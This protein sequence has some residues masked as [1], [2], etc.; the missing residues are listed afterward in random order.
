MVFQSAGEYAKIG[1]INLLICG[2]PSSNF[3]SCATA[4]RFALYRMPLFA[5][6]GSQEIKFIYF[7]KQHIY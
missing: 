4:N 7:I 3:A 2:D 1:V 6:R 5:A